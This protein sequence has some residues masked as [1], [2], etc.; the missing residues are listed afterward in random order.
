MTPSVPFNHVTTTGNAR[1]KPRKEYSG[2]LWNA[3]RVRLEPLD[4][5]N[6]LETSFGIRRC[7]RPSRGYASQRY[8]IALYYRQ[9]QRSRSVTSRKRKKGIEASHLHWTA[10]WHLRTPQHPRHITGPALAKTAL[11]LQLRR[12]RISHPPLGSVAALCVLGP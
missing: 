10:D 7:Q 4:G 3:P 6:R 9:V 11:T 8:C 2:V 12:T 5:G 1:M